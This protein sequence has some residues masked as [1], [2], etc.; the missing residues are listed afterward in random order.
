MAAT[1][2]PSAPLYFSIVMATGIVSLAARQHDMSRI[3]EALFRL[4]ATAYLIVWIFTLVHAVRFPRALWRD[5]ADH[6]RGPGFFASVAA[7][8]V[9]G[10]QCMVLASDFAIAKVLWV[11]AL[12]LW[13]GLTYAV[14]VALTVNAQK[15]PL[16]EG[17]SGGWLLAV[18]ATQSIA[19]LSAYLAPHVEYRIQ[20]DFFALSLWLVGGMLYIWIVSLIFYRYTFFRFAPADVSPS[21]WINMGAMAISTLAGSLLIANAGDAGLLASLRPFLEGFTVLCWATGTWWIPFLVVLVA[22]K[23]GYA[24]SPLAYEL[25]HWS[26]V[27]PLGMYAVCTFEMS[28]ALHLEFLEAMT[29]YLTYVALAAWALAFVS[30]VRYAVR[31]I[32]VRWRSDSA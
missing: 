20:L 17:I 32:A 4:N 23:H 19:V 2:K 21:Y 16:D 11:L 14:F 24:R 12:A 9:L 31:A 6:A 26:A 1:G 18:V 8:A 7:T 28:R 13:T 15:P 22:W 29:R 27:F 25:S 10:S 3:A 5:L 30:F